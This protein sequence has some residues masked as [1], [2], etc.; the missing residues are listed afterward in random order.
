ML[1]IAL[2]EGHSVWTLDLTSGR[3]HHVAGSGQKGYNSPGA[4]SS[5]EARFNGPKGIAV[6]KSGVAYVVDT[7][8]QAI[9]RI[10]DGKVRTIAGAGPQSRGYRGDGGPA[11]QAWLDRPHGVCVSEDGVVFIGDTNNH[12]VRRLRPART[13]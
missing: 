5:R 12:R 6:D 7:E 8:N 10:A 1:W 13:D 3:L 2:R 4:T 9:R 11:T